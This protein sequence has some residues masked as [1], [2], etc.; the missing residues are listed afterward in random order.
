MAAATGD[1]VCVRLE[2][3]GAGGH[4]Q[5][6]MEKLRRRRSEFGQNCLHFF[7]EIHCRLRV[8]EQLQFL[9]PFVRTT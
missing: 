8:Q 6:G 5:Q 1:G 2:A 3:C 4:G 7:G 9:R